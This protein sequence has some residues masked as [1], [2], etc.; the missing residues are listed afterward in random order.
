MPPAMG[1][2]FSDAQW[3]CPMAGDS[4]SGCV[5]ALSHGWGQQF[6][7]CTVALYHG[8][9]QGCT[10][11]DLVDHWAEYRAKPRSMVKGIPWG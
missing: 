1:Q 4:N 5:V 6:S 11:W 3:H 8:W 7:G 9:G 2:Q 10:M